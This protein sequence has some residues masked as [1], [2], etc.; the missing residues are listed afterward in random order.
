MK[1]ETSSLNESECCVLSDLF[2]WAEKANAYIYGVDI[3]REGE[4]SDITLR[5]TRG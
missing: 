2:V 1:K 4:K 3:E 5:F